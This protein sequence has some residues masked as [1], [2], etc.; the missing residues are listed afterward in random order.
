VREQLE[1]QH[2]I[3]TYLYQIELPAVRVRMKG[4]RGQLEILQA[5]F[6]HTD[7][8]LRNLQEISVSMDRRELNADEAIAS[9]KELDS[10]LQTVSLRLQQ[11]FPS[12]RHQTVEGLLGIVENFHRFLAQ[13]DG[14]G[15]SVSLAASLKHQTFSALQG[16]W[17]VYDTLIHRR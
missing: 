6:L 10:Q 11:R 17:Q 16:L 8:L 2:G 14:Q 9:L 12:P 13:T 15:S 4:M 7:D 5:A 1:T 3:D